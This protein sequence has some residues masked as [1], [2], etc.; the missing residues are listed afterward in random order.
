MRRPAMQKGTLRRT[1]GR[2]LIALVAAFVLASAARTTAQEVLKIPGLSE[3]VHDVLLSFE[4]DG[5][6]SKIYFEEGQTVEKGQMILS[7]NKWLEEL[8]VKRNKLI[9]ESKVE[10]NSAAERVKTLKSMYA[11]TLELFKKTGSVSKDEL[12]QLELE[13]KLATA[14]H[15]RL[16]IAEE[17]EKIEYDMARAK[18]AKLEL[19]SP[20]QGVISAL[21]L[22]EGESCESRQPVVRIVDASSCILVCNVEASLGIDLRKNQVVDL[23]VQA[24]A[25][26]VRKKGRIFFISPVVDPASGLYQVKTEF[27]NKDGGIKPGVEGFMMLTRP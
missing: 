14:E 17:R 10:L 24:G 27:E 6:I 19:K 8:E 15:D 1:A 20:I 16:Q 26:T 13:Y 5:M 4:I 2:V 3:P 7:L 22:D 18:L 12:E 23:T 25:G 21:M 11:S 9:W